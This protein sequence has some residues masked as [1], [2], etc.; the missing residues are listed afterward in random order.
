MVAGQRTQQLSRSNRWVVCVA[1]S[2]ACIVVL[3]YAVS[4]TI[5]SAGDGLPCC[6]VRG[7]A[8]GDVNHC[9]WYCPVADGST[10]ARGVGSHVF[11]RN[12]LS[13]EETGVRLLIPARKR[14]DQRVFLCLLGVLWQVRRKV[15]SFPSVCDGMLM[16]QRRLAI[17]QRI[18]GAVHEE[19]SHSRSV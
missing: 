19:I 6:I 13:C 8:C 18:A 5:M 3:R 2:R 10:R 7:I 16:F 15:Q 14:P 11:L 4:C 17:M 1:S 12:S 9:V